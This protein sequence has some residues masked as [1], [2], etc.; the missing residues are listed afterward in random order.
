MRF[1]SVRD[2]RGKSAWVWRE[3]NKERELVL[4]SN[5][6]PFAILLSV[7][8]DSLEE[9]LSA[10]RQAQAISA[11]TGMQKRSTEAGTTRMTLE[12][13]NAE[14]AEVRKNRRR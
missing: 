7:S 5:G 2:L 3:L 11:I 6:K 4:T 10:I 13:I 12:E 1:V 14:I 8:E 9:S